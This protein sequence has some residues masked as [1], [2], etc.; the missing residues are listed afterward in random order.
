LKL[1]TQKNNSVEPHAAAASIAHHLW[2]FFASARASLCETDQSISLAI[3]QILFL[4]IR[5]I[6]TL[7]LLV[8]VLICA[9][10]L[11]TFAMAALD[12]VIIVDVTHVEI[13]G[14][15]T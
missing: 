14:F 5:F 11:S 13:Y 4:Y 6:I 7:P 3:E 9:H 15:A 2:H 1:D 8:V 12:K 10:E